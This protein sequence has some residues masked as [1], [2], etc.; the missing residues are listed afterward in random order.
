MTYNIRTGAKENVEGEMG[1][2]K[3]QN[4]FQRPVTAIGM[5]RAK[6]LLA[7]VLSGLLVLIASGLAQG[8]EW[9]PIAGSEE[10]RNFMSGL[11]AERTLPNGE[12]SLGEYNPYGTGTLF[13]WGTAIPRTWEIKGDDLICL[14]AKRESICYQI[15]KNI[16]RMNL[17]RARDI[18]TGR[19]AEFEVT[20]GKAVITGD[21]P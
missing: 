15:E 18:S 19:M 14:T 5:D 3:R 2:M 12:V 20:D 6:R 21:A 7:V 16:V 13:A 10:L 11:K 1:L 4:H 9:I 8:S 17:F